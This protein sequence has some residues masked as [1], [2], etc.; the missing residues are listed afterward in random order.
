VEKVK[1]SY[2]PGHSVTSLPCE[3]MA[4]PPE[5]PL[6]TGDKGGEERLRTGQPQVP[7]P[8]QNGMNSPHITT[9]GT[10]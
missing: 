1:L 2:I 8:G 4:G 9:E 3:G 7:S 5:R 10:I 6:S